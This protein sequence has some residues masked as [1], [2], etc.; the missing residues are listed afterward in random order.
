MTE[1][2]RR[3]VD[4]FAVYLESTARELSVT[5]IAEEFREDALD[6]GK[7]T[8]CTARGLQQNSA[9][10]IVSVTLQARNEGNMPLLAIVRERNSG[11]R[12]LVARRK[13]IFCSFAG[14]IILRALVIG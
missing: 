12:D 10:H 6:K 4:Q 13:K 14:T 1:A 3:F 5:E 2:K 11:S 7:T 8:H 9:L